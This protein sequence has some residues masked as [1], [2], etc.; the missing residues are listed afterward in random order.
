MGEDREIGRRGGPAP[1]PALAYAGRLLADLG[2]DRP[3]ACDVDHPALAWRRAGL[4][5]VTGLAEGEGLVCPSAL[6]AAADGVLIALRA[7]VPDPSRLPRHGAALLGE[8]ARLMGLTRNGR[9][10]ANRACR[11]V[12][13]ADGRIALNLARDEDRDL[14]PFLLGSDACD[15]WADIDAAALRWPVAELVRRGIEL[16][17]PIAAADVERPTRLLARADGKENRAAPFVV[18]LSALWAGPLAASLLALIGADVVKVES[19]D[20][21][22]GARRGNADFYALLNAG[23]RS[24]TFDFCDP[25]DLKR[26][27]ALLERADIVIEGSRPR[28]LARLGID[29][30]EYVRGGCLWISIIAY[31]DPDRVGLGDEAAFAAG[32]ADVMA[33]GWGQPCFAGDAIA[34]PLTGL[35]AALAAW[36][37]W[38]GAG[39]LIPLSLSGTTSFALCERV[40]TG[41]E[42]GEWQD[43]ALSDREPL[44]PM[45]TP[46]GAMRAPGEDNH[47]LAAR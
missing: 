12:D 16:G 36:A 28:A 4:M 34:D 41:P 3:L 23:K 45:R 30:D 21:L 31:D 44:Y 18:D 13:A 42:L 2:I 11:I 39:R 25:V 22:D 29:R 47:V 8:R 40:A 27:K 9:L 15:G 19:A 6:A 37:G 33:A 32:L 24:L 35:H 46:S 10:S 5:E 7:I 38:G 1:L 43:M 17:L 20:R 26:L 14:V